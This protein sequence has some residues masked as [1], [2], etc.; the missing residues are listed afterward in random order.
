MKITKRDLDTA[1]NEPERP[2]E[3]VGALLSRAQAS[4]STALEAL[5]RCIR[6]VASALAASEA[7]TGWEATIAQPKGKGK[8]KGEKPA[9]DYNDKMA[10]HLAWLTKNIAQIM[11]E[12][13]KLDAHERKSDDELT[14]AIVLSYL[15][16][17]DVSERAHLLREA[18]RIDEVRSGL[19]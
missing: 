3:D 5:D 1:Q 15:R 18:A 7:P 17:L 4:C 9:S 11:G 16:A 8:S 6:H 13:R 10:S 19:A 2:T 12:L 14:P